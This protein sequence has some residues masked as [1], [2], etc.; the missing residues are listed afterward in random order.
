MMSTNSSPLAVRQERREPESSEGTWARCRDPDTPPYE[1][2]WEREL[3]ML[4]SLGARSLR[5]SNS[6]ASA[7]SFIPSAAVVAFPSVLL[8]PQFD[9]LLPESGQKFIQGLKHFHH[10]KSKGF[11]FLW[12]LI[13]SVTWRHTFLSDRVSWLWEVN[14]LCSGENNC[15]TFWIVLIE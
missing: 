4:P 11:N 1:C 9:A 15:W 8:Q 7:T 14:Q 2:E 5:K 13:S 3:R 6:A 12:S 10:K